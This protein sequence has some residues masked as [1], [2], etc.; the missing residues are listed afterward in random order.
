[1]FQV[2]MWCAISCMVKPMD[3][4]G[5]RAH[6]HKAESSTCPILGEVCKGGHFFFFSF[7]G[8]G[9]GERDGECEN[10]I[11]KILNF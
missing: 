2:E 4:I 7:W 1:M 10:G 11:F 6:T 8:A 5:I 3:C 9:G